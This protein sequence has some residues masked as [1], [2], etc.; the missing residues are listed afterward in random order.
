M[1][2]QNSTL[3][4]G[5]LAASL[6]LLVAVFCV[7]H[8]TDGEVDSLD[9]VES[10]DALVVRDVLVHPS[11][12]SGDSEGATAS[13]GDTAA[14]EETEAMKDR[15]VAFLSNPESSIVRGKDNVIVY[16]E[17]VRSV[18]TPIKGS[19]FKQAIFDV[20]SSE[21]AGALTLTEKTKSAVEAEMDLA[22][23][24]AFLLS[25]DQYLPFPLSVS[26]TV[27][28]DI[29]KVEEQGLHTVAL[30]G[31][32]KD[33]PDS[34]VRL[35]FHDGAVAGSV[36]LLED[37]S[38]FE[39]GMAG[40]GDVAIRLLD[41][42]KDIYGECAS[43]DGSHLHEE[44]MDD[45]VTPGGD[46]APVLFSNSGA[47]AAA[48]SSNYASIIDGVV[49]YTTRVKNDAGGVA[50]IEAKVLLSTGYINDALERSEI[51]NTF[52]TLLG[53]VEEVGHSKSL[54]NTFEDIELGE[55][56]VNDLRL[57]LG[58]DYAAA[59]YFGGGG[60]ANMN[61]VYYV[62]GKDTLTAAGSMVHEFGH[63]LGCAHAWADT[64]G[65]RVTA[66][67][68][69]Y[70]GW[71]FKTSTGTKV[72]TVMSYTGGW[73]T[74]RIGYFSNPDISYLGGMTG[75]P[76]GY[77]ASGHTDI[78]Q[79]LVSGGA[80]G[81]AGPGYDGS[82]PLLGADNHA[83]ISE[84]ALSY[85]S[86]RTR[87]PTSILQPVGYTIYYIGR[88]EQI[89]WLGGDHS[90]SVE[91]ELYKGGLLHSSIATL[92][93]AHL[94]WQDWT[95]PDV[96]E[97]DDYS[98]RVTIV[99]EDILETGPFTIRQVRARADDIEIQAIDGL[100]VDITLPT[101]EDLT[102]GYFYEPPMNGALTGT[103]PDLVYTP[104][105]GA[106]TDSFTYYTTY[107]DSVTLE[108]SEPATVSIIVATE[109]AH[110][111]LDDGS[112][113]VVT[114][115]SGN[116]H[117]GTF[118]ATVDSDTWEGTGKVDGALRFKGD[119]DSVTL[120]AAAFSGLTNQMTLSMWVYGDGNQPTND[121][122]F[123]MIDGNGDTI[124]TML[125]GAKVATDVANY[126]FT[127][128][129]GE[130][131]NIYKNADSSDFQGQWNHYVFVKN[132][133][134]REMKMYINGALSAEITNDYP[135]AGAAEVYLGSYNSS[136]SS[137]N[138]MIDS[139]RLYDVEMTAAGVAKLYRIESAITPVVEFQS[140]TV[141]KNYFQNISL[142]SSSDT[143]TYTI[144]DQPAH[145]W[146]SGTAPDL[147]YTPDVN[148]EG[149]DS[150]TFYASEE[151]LIS[152]T[153]TVSL[154]V[155]EV[156]ALITIPASAAATGYHATAAQTAAWR[157]TE[158]DK[159]SLAVE[160][161]D[162]FGAS[163]SW[164]VGDGNSNGTGTGASQTQDNSPV[165]ATNFVRHGTT[166]IANVNLETYD[167]PTLAISAAVADVAV[168]AAIGGDMGNAGDW[169]ELLTFDITA[170]TPDKFRLGIMAGAVTGTSGWTPAGLRLSFE[171]GSAVAV[172]ELDV[173]LGMVFF[174]ID[175]ADSTSGTFTI[176]GQNRANTQGAT[177]T[178]V[179]FDVIPSAYETWLSDFPTLADISLQGD[180]DE[181]GIK[182]ILEYVLNGDPSQAGDAIEISTDPTGENV[183]FTFIRRAN[184]AEEITQIFQHS[185]NLSGE[186]T[187]LNITEPKDAK[188]SLSPV[189]DGL[190]TVTVSISKSLV[191]GDAHFGRLKVLEEE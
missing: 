145:G 119:T 179:T 46:S 85:P 151:G 76:N 91:I 133:D 24:R 62:A 106:T 55:L 36:E 86:H 92:S 33:R 147:V 90:Q 18:R 167:D 120:P 160:T 97:A 4:R 168:G 174:D 42:G 104:N 37:Q 131:S 103:A 116:G 175:V 70:Y 80:I 122:L 26:E 14:I 191:E 148:F 32:V 108:T 190:Q 184:S 88:E 64:E 153:A 22:A 128:L 19:V 61:G 140:V 136:L 123:H 16:P 48:V 181:D 31:M 107:D 159:G 139:V 12:V 28:L 56:A 63:L 154:N 165:W 172:T 100:A 44:L 34:Q 17:I 8:D 121:N 95:V 38:Y 164:F 102:L 117:H 77:D 166:T 65:S 114:D 113:A 176:E 158:V 110:W 173:E 127:G 189:V 71:R 7:Y 188:V 3:W 155:I 130:Y 73:A 170:A 47:A 109:V 81:T 124:M 29:Q 82:N 39:L 144:V 6:F 156:P 149:A 115:V 23:V 138:G 150:F 141:A 162:A 142:I 111:P 183:V 49:G 187:D 11:P 134:A 152:N 105:S 13:S 43:C 125:I 74:Q 126:W 5:I 98:I 157:S 83:E 137:Y 15:G 51:T 20:R 53:T 21:L 50:E 41:L 66:T 118:T 35:V 89:S 146:I 143:V 10:S 129:N 171:G 25:D 84:N 9:P 1:T 87:T 69:H 79:Q 135:V 57:T 78:D 101:V 54:A 161:G 163:G 112:G 96:E 99:G 67:N 27:L 40:N 68:E 93:G 59:V 45:E 132:A 186:W 2:T 180:P 72:R 169:G 60:V 178:G 94:R 185:S 177:L 52:V 182:T 30:V 75:V 58:A